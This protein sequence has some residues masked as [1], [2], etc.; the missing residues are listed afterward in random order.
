MLHLFFLQSLSHPGRRQRVSK[1]DRP[2]EAWA[3]STY[4][5]LSRFRVV[6]ILLPGEA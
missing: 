2:M 6:K 3:V 5:S 4:L 1:K